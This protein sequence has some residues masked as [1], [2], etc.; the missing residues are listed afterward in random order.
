M[1]IVVVVAAY[2]LIGYVVAIGTAYWEART[3]DDPPT[4]LPARVL[5]QVTCW[6][7]ILLWTAWKAFCV[8]AA[9]ARR[10]GKQVRNSVREQGE[11]RWVRHH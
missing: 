7:M 11:T 9:M 2:L 6:G 4:F 3:Q 8:P 5:L 10:I 1:G